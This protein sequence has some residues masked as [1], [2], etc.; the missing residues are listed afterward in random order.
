MSVKLFLLKSGEYV[1]SDGKEL[2]SDEKS[3]GYLFDNPYKVVMTAPMFTAEEEENSI[4]VSL[5]PWIILSNDKKIPIP[6]DWVVTVLEPIETLK[7]MYEDQVNGETDK[8]S[9]FN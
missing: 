9:S 7:Q 6:F 3:V 1:V 2:L 5:T 8:D 4:K